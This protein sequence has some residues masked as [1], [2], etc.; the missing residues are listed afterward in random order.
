MVVENQMECL[1][2]S[3]KFYVYPAARGVITIL[4]YVQKKHAPSSINIRQIW[5]NN[6]GKFAI[7]LGANRIIFV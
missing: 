5:S 6:K 7:C 2:R 4:R 3:C 1:H